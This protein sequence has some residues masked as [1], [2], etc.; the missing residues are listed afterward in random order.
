MNDVSYMKQNV[1]IYGIVSILI[2]CKL[3]FF[4]R[5]VDPVSDGQVNDIYAHIEHRRNYQLPP[6]HKISYGLLG[7]YNSYRKDP[8]AASE[9]YEILP[10]KEASI[11][12]AVERRNIENILISLGFPLDELTGVDEDSGDIYKLRVSEDSPALTA[13]PWD[14]TSNNSTVNYVKVYIK[15]INSVKTNEP[16][17]KKY[18]W[19]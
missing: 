10:E 5:K 14:S 1:F 16:K 9:E 2:K 3:K 19:G 13:N 11:Q 18:V 12:E 4:F 17:K 6:N 15:D 7:I 8:E